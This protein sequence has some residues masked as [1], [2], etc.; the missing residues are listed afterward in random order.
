[1]MLLESN[2]T[3]G[4]TGK[5]L[6]FQLMEDKKELISLLDK[7]GGLTILTINVSLYSVAH[8]LTKNEVHDY[9]GYRTISNA[10]K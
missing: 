10:S 2:L 8:L 7:V 9:Q 1:M 3:V 6:V 5:M 4:E